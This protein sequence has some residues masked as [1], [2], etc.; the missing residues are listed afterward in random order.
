MEYRAE[1]D[2]LLNESFN[3]YN[4]Y[5]MKKAIL[6]DADGVLTVPE[7]LFSVMYSRSHGLDF[8]PF[9]RFFSTEWAEY[10]TGKKDL[11]K[12]IADNPGLWQWPGTPDELLE[13][14]FKT[15]DIRND[16]LISLIKAIR[17][18][19]TPCYLATEQEKYRGAYMKNVMFKDLFD[20][21]FITADIGIKKSEPAFFVEIIKRLNQ[22]GQEISPGEVIFFDD[23]QSKVESALKAGLD[24]CL[25][26][27]VDGVRQKLAEEN[28][29][30]SD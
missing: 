28:I 27:G 4:G 29:L 10:V 14:W 2:G 25:Y 9:E 26:D 19:G 18:S 16:E 20:D 13:Y 5:I 17:N 23:S 21:Y 7:E 11:K 6:F 30:Q 15:E 24:A 22:A 8:E 12:F 1:M 3:M